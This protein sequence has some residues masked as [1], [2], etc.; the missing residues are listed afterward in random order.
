MVVLEANPEVK[1][2][3]VEGALQDVERASGFDIWGPVGG[4]HH[5]K[6]ELTEC[7]F[8]P[9]MVSVRFYAHGDGRGWQ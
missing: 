1:P 5:V 6:R 2:R 3:L 8:W 4:L 9:M 7:I